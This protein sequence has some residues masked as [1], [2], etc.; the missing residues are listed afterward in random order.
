MHA[1]IL[2]DEGAQCTFTSTQLAAELQIIPKF[3]TQVALPSF[4]VGSK[5]LQT[6]DTATV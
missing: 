4:G 5:S 2:F 1:S 6:K 3:T